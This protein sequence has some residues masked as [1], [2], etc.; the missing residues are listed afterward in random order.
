[1][2][3][4]ASAL[5]GLVMIVGFGYFN[6]LV[7][8]RPYFIGLGF[9]GWFLPGVLMITC[10]WY[11]QRRNRFALRGAIGVCAMQACFAIALFIANFL[12]T[13]ISIVPI[14]MTLLW[15]LAAG[16]L[17]IQ[18]WRARP[19]VDS[20][21]EHHGAFEAHVIPVAQRADEHA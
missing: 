20:D 4:I 13:P 10:W 2:L 14:V 7:R 5:F 16:Q 9:L 1:L 12:L 21:A 6:R 8:F 15:T 17:L 3:G 18:L 19:I 11:L